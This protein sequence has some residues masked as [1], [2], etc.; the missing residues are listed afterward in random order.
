MAAALAVAVAAGGGVGPA[1]ASAAS[2]GTRLDAVTG[3]DAQG[4]PPIVFTPGAT[5]VPVHDITISESSP[6]LLAAGATVC[7]VLSGATFATTSSPTVTASDGGAVLAANGAQFIAVSITKSS[8][9]AAAKDVAGAL[10]IDAPATGGPVAVNV[11]LLQPASSMPPVGDAPL[12]RRTT[13]G[14]DTAA[15]LAAAASEN[16]CLVA[17]GVTGALEIGSVPLGSVVSQSRVFGSDRYDTAATLFL[18]GPLAG[19]SAA[20]P[21]VLAATWEGATPACHTLAVL[22][23]GE[24]YPDALAANYL[25]GRSG[26]ATQILLTEQAA[27]PAQTTTALRLAGVSQVVIVGGPVAVS[28]AVA[29]QLAATAA[30]ACGG[31]KPTGTNL[32]V[33]RIAGAT[34]FDT[35]AAIAEHSGAAAV[36]TLSLSGQPAAAKPTAIVAS[37]NSFADALAAGPMVYGGTASVTDGNGHGFPLLLTSPTSLS[38]QTQAA[39][40]A[41]GITQVLIPGGSAAVSPAVEQQID[42]LGITTIRFAGTDRTDTATLVATFETTPASALPQAGLSYSI[43]AVDLVRGDTFADALTV[44]GYAWSIGTGTPLLMAVNPN[45]LG[46]ATTAYLQRTGAAPPAP[47]LGTGTINVFGGPGALS[48]AVVNAAASALAGA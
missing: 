32:S 13:T 28:Q 25:A 40:K 36:G 2:A 23:S 8:V 24:N 7:L 15:G 46:P 45:N 26:L 18:G 21:G 1:R 43:A 48:A 27:L 5:A 11:T 39:L 29:D 44:P 35:A 42:A 19:F 4:G 10:A 41:L 16:E 30:Y 6:G 34:R 47:G 14:L 37:G 33:S 3:I 38:P 20:G 9:G 12:L 31:T 22:A 17:P